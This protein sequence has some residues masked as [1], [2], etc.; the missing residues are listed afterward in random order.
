[1]AGKCRRNCCPEGQELHNCAWGR[2]PSPPRRFGARV[3][4]GRRQ[5]ASC[6]SSCRRLT[7]GPHRER[8][9]LPWLRP[10]HCVPGPGETA[11]LPRG[12]VQAHACWREGLRCP[13]VAEG[14]ADTCQAVVGT[15]CTHISR[16]GFS[17]P[18]TAWHAVRARG[19]SVRFG[20]HRW[21]AV[22]A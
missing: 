1:M 22:A 19:Q 18:C 15:I 10:G 7:M 8:G 11:F 4:D 14:C 2:P 3:V 5:G 12:R 21:L 9:C 17:A 16:P 20:D 6:A 13:P